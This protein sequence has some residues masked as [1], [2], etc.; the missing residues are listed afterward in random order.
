MNS[1]QNLVLQAFISVL[2]INFKNVG[3]AAEMIDQGH[4][5]LQDSA[6]KEDID[7]HQE[8]EHC[9]SPGQV[10][11]MSMIFQ[12]NTRPGSVFACPGCGAESPR[13]GGGETVW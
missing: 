7:L 2:K 13:L 12:D 1:Y 3:R 6:L 8:W 5:V 11:D 9:F 10:V 4:F